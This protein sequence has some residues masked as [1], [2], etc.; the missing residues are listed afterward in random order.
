VGVVW[1]RM[2]AELRSRWQAL[3]V[4][5]VVVGALGG[6]A[7]AAAAGA[8]RAETAYPRFLRDERAMDLVVAPF[9]PDRDQGLARV[10]SLPGVLDSAFVNF[11]IASVEGPHGRRLDFPDVFPIVSRGGRFGSALN[12]LKILRGRNADPSRP[13]EAVAS[14][15]VAERLGVDP[16][17][18][19]TLTLFTGGPFGPGPRVRPAPVRLEIVGVGIAPGE[20]QTLAGGFLPGLHLTPA[21]GRVHADF[22][23]RTNE[24][25]AVRLRDGT[26]GVPA[27]RHEVRDIHGS[28]RVG[29]DFP[30]IQTR[31][32]DAVQQAVRVQVVALR[33]AAVLV[34]IAG[35]AVFAQALARQTFL[36]SVEYPALRAIGVTP[37][38]LV[39]LGMARSVLVAGGGVAVALV[40]AV[41]LSPL[42]P[43]G[44]ARVAEPDP[45]LSIDAPLIALGVLAMVAAIAVVA[46]VPAW[47]AARLARASAGAPGLSRARTSAL[48][49]WLS[50][51]VRAPSAGA[52]VRMALER[53]AGRTAVP[54]GTTILGTAL[55][56]LAITG[57]LQFDASLHHLAVTPRLSGWNW[58]A[59]VGTDID[60]R[61][62]PAKS[63]A[64]H[65][66]LSR[67]LLTDQRVASY[68]IGGLP[69]L[70]VDRAE[71]PGLALESRK[72]LVEP[73]LA[74]GRLPQAAD[75]IAL[76]TEVM[77]ASGVGIGDEV[78]VGYRATETT[79]H[80]VGRIAMPSLYFS[81]TGPGDG[82]AVTMSWLRQVDPTA[83][84]QVGYFVR[85]E[86]GTDQA[87]AMADIRRGLDQF[88]S[89][90]R[91]TASELSTLN[92][93]G[94]LPLALAGILVL[95]AAATLAHTLV[96]SIRR[97]RR[98][99]AVLKTVG[100]SRRQLFATVAW[101]ASTIA[102]TAV[103]LGVPVG[104]VA[105]RLAW[106]V[107]AE[108]L[109]VVPEAVVPLLAVLLVLPVT[110]V[111]T[112]LV[113][114]VPAR[115]AATT[116]P[117]TVLR[118]E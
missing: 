111:I 37:R 82:A 11:A 31:Q 16:G 34:A 38:Q 89:L 3:A 93:I 76:G 69:G 20:F 32:T 74:D 113:A 46:L 18:R 21:F 81:F 43:T 83:D 10:R 65:R 47:R 71:V 70:R 52:G 23:D 108:R 28:L 61:L 102:A 7:I 56:L 5:A 60:N 63:A 33:V 92:E 105:G 53:G 8:V 27:F 91:Q 13:D 106:N 41:A 42:T 54:V 88:F 101:Q 55:G 95:M 35:L 112:N 109:G 107:L 98:D 72:G 39:S 87:A 118:S 19:V 77:R 99:L 29:F 26:A 1:M 100:F 40:V 12:G 114:A 36:E 117:A 9:G 2:R 15:S 44:I 57:A 48:A 64:I 116:N 79:M 110:L 25:L 68:A 97:R 4:L 14:L 58:D 17:D 24:A 90:P 75:E 66:V 73:S 86:P 51:V 59:L 49:G 78:T 94:N 104:V 62:P 96:T 22:L 30:V 80:V 85:F 6:G 103:L 67:R 84:A 115:R 50:R 45:G